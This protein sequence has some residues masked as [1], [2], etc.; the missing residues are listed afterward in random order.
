MWGFRPGVG[1]MHDGRMGRKKLG[2][3]GERIGLVRWSY[4]GEAWLPEI[5]VGIVSKQAS[6]IW[7]LDS[8]G[9]THAL[10]KSDWTMYQP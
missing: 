4:V 10:N 9:Q 1:S 7:H 3:V 2:D 5:V 6:G 8:N